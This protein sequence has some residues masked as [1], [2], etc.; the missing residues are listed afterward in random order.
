MK[1]YSDRIQAIKVRDT[2][3]RRK[4]LGKCRGREGFISLARINHVAQLQNIHKRLHV[5]AMLFEN[6]EID[7][8]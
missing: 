2:A 7:S 1:E 6:E 4:K 5:Q 3:L 8:G